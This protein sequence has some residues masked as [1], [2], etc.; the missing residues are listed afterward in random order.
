MAEWAMPRPPYSKK[1]MGLRL[2]GL[3]TK[4]DWLLNL[5]CDLPETDRVMLLM[6][7]GH[8]ALNEGFGVNAIMIR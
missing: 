7:K 1:S 5:R 4:K 6:M 2:T 8:L 3:N